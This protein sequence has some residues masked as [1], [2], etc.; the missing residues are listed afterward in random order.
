MAQ[1]LCLPVI[2]SLYI[3]QALIFYSPETHPRLFIHL[4]TILELAEFA[5]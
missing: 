2:A 5:F 1:E 3:S 4:N